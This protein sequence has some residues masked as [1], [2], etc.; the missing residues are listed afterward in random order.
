MPPLNLVFLG[1]GA[2]T[3]RHGRALSQRREAVRC[4]YASRDA[5]RAMSYER[6]LGNS[7]SYGSYEAALED[8]R[9]DAVLVAT[10]PHL[11]LALTLAALAKG[12]HVIVEKPAFMRAADC[13]VAAEAMAR[14]GR[15]VLVAENYCYKPLTRALRGALAAGVVGETRFVQLNAFKGQP[16]SGWRAGPPYAGALLEG[17]IH[18]IDLL[19]HLGSPVV[20]AHGHRAGPPQGPERSTLLVVEYADGAVGTLSHSWETPSPLRGLQLS[21]IRGT[22]GSILF[23]SNG[24]FVLERGRRRRLVLPGLADVAGYRAMFD[25]FLAAL[26]GEREPLMTLGRARDDL[27]LVEAALGGGDGPAARPRHRTPGGS[28]HLDLGDVQG[29]PP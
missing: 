25:D 2:I 4:F 8:G 29:Q 20:A 26:R 7:G 18:W 15:R 22:E 16:A 3:A 14:A 13:D 17:G 24:A 27:A 1:C 23:E 10:P 12:K 28:P 11:H 19:A 5:E 6:R 21:R 9:M